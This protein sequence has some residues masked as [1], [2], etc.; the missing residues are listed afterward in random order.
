MPNR[1]KL[2]R[3]AYERDFE[4]CVFED[5]NLKEIHFW[6]GMIVKV[7]GSYSDNL[8]V[9]SER[10]YDETVQWRATLQLGNFEP[11]Y[12]LHD[13]EREAEASKPSFLGEGDTFSVEEVIVRKFEDGREDLIFPRA[14]GLGPAGGPTGTS[15]PDGVPL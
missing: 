1:K 12:S 3:E 11:T 13:L 14:H 9:Y 4:K 8:A 6:G 5:G 7:A 2:K 10:D 15:G